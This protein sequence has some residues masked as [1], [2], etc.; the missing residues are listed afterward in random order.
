[1]LASHRAIACASASVAIGTSNAGFAGSQSRLLW[2][3]VAGTNLAS[4]RSTIELRT[5]EPVSQSLFVCPNRKCGLALQSPSKYIGKL[6]RCPWCKTPIMVPTPS[7]QP[8]PRFTQAGALIQCW[9]RDCKQRI[10]V[11][12]EDFNRTVQCPRC[13]RYLR[14]VVAARGKKIPMDCRHCGLEL[15][16]EKRNRGHTVDCPNCG[17]EIVVPYSP[18]LVEALITNNRA[19]STDSTVAIGLALGA[20]AVLALG[21]VAV[22]GALVLG[23]VSVVGL[24]ASG[25][26]NQRGCSCG[27]RQCL[28]CGRYL[29]NPT[30]YCYEHQ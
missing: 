16:I 24:A 25:C 12:E 27:R 17:G 23:A 20:A 26:N 22:I 10:H 8:I 11:V 7:S 4:V 13:K 5:E 18:I 2:L 6:I 9:G 14:A 21:A 30:N 1:M 15:E 3:R 19:H 29:R 28:T